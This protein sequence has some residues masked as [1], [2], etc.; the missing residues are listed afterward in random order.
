MQ[1]H[2]RPDFERPTD[3]CFRVVSFLD[4]LFNQR[5]E[6][7]VNGEVVDTDHVVG[8]DDRRIQRTGLTDS[9]ARPVSVSA[10]KLREKAPTRFC[11]R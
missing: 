3:D 9:A 1:Q 4:G 8:E 5:R 10:G 6:N 2:P 7:F 11:A